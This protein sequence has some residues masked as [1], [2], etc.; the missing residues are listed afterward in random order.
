[1]KAFRGNWNQNDPTADDYIKNR[2]FYSKEGLVEVLPETTLTGD[3]VTLN[4]PLVVGQEYKIIFDDVEYTSI[5]RLYDGYIMI[6]NNAVYEHDNGI[7]TDTGEPFAM[8]TNGSDTEAFIYI[9]N[10]ISTYDSDASVASHT[11]HILT[12][13]E[14]IYKLDKKYLPDDI[15]TTDKLD[16]VLPENLVTSDDIADVV[17]HTE[18]N[19]TTDQQEQARTNIG[20]GTSNFSGSYVDLADVPVD[21][22]SY[23]DL[24]WPVSYSDNVCFGNG[25]FVVLTTN[26]VRYSDDGIHW[27]ASSSV[28]N[29]CHRLCYG[30]DKF[31][32]FKVSTYNSSKYVDVCYSTD[33]DVW[34][35]RAKAV[36]VADTSKYVRT[37][38]YGNDKFVGI[39]SAT[40]SQ[41]RQTIYSTD[42]I[43]WST[44]T[45][46][47][48]DKWKSICYG[49]GKFVA[50][51]FRSV[52]Y[53]ED[54]IKWTLALEPETTTG[55]FQYDYVYYVNNMFI[56][57]RS[58]NY[59]DDMSGVLYSEDGIN[60]STASG[61]DIQAPLFYANGTYIGYSMKNDM[62]QYSF[63]GTTWNNCS[64]SGSMDSIKHDYVHHI[65]YGNGLFIAAP[66][67]DDKPYFVSTDGINW[68][69]RVL[70]TNEGVATEE[71]ASAIS[72][73]ISIEESNIPDTIARV[74]DIPEQVQPDWN[75]T[76][77]TNPAYIKNKPNLTGANAATELPSDNILQVNTMYFIGEVTTL[78]VGFPTAAAVGD[79]VYISFSTGGTTPTFTFTT[80]NHIGLDTINKLQNY[81][82][83][84]IG[85]WN[86]QEWV[87]A[88][89]EVEI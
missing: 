51:G 4:F 73:Y 14:V 70:I 2:P 19:L 1:M 63:D 84:L 53:S 54:G 9:S 78:S 49:N 18:Q 87:F 33:G 64:L 25:R 41:S 50:L 37:I 52:M 66:Y 57:C 12:V 24:I 59:V 6:G 55:T 35:T 40:S 75:Q 42:G 44:A 7:E 13:Q 61:W 36:S 62:L 8:E 58:S 76:D 69:D 5:A 46:G 86:G 77:E 39:M 29:G 34:T 23:K 80:N 28:T 47:R 60:W 31:V 85:M 32:T 45:T 22:V 27:S 68:T 67:S 89:H 71:I 56:M 30:K 82:Y 26:Y 88:I 72:P 79:M 16:E 83:E 74:S 3:S 11:I 15:V 38:C 43:N 10:N 48:T 20:A 17:R 21:I 81:N 65:T